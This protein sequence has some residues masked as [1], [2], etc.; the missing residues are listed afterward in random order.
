MN[1]PTEAIVKALETKGRGA[2]DNGRLPAAARRAPRTK[3]S[4]AS[5][6]RAVTIGPWRCDSC[7]EPGIGG[8]GLLTHFN[9]TG[10]TRFSPK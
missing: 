8:P 6:V 10:H 1:K 9:E 4:V 7:G 5:A 2:V 3:A